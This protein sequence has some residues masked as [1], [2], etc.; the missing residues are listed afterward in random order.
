M[1]LIVVAPVAALVFVYG[2]LKPGHVNHAVVGPVEACYADELRGDLFA[3]Q[4]RAYPGAVNV[5][6]S[7]RIF[8]GFA[9]DV[10]NARLARLDAFEGASYRRVAAT[11]ESGRLVWVYEYRHALE[12]RGAPLGAWREDLDDASA[13][14]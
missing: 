9:L 14:D 10:A 12:V 2:T 8:R 3:L 5:A 11:T 6:R 7:T 4:A 13:C 1:S